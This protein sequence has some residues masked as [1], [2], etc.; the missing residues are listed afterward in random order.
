M[1]C[2]DNMA[3]GVAVRLIL[4]IFGCGVN[5]QKCMNMIVK[6]K[7]KM[8]IIMNMDTGIDTLSSQILKS[9]SGTNFVIMSPYNLPPYSPSLIPL[10][11]CTVRCCHT[12]A[13]R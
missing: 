3:N 5:Y 8:N 10:P 11:Y 6:I 9:A 13:L 1:T 7:M 12:A 4:K 2:W